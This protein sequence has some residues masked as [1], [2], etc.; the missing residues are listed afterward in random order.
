VLCA[1]TISQ[2]EN[3]EASFPAGI[4]MIAILELARSVDFLALAW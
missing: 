3:R 4:L 2:N 1:S